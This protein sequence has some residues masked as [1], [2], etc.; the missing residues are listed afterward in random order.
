MAGTRSQRVISYLRLHPRSTCRQ[1]ARA[2]GM[3]SAAV[4]HHLRG[5]LAEK[6]IRAILVPGTG[7][8]RPA[9]EYVIGNDLLGNNGS[10][11]A[12]ALL[13]DAR[14]RGQVAR[15]A[16]EGA[17][18]AALVSACGPWAA[19]AGLASVQMLVARLNDQNYDARWEAGSEGPRILLANCPYREIV[20]KSPELC[21]VDR[22]LIAH[23]SKAQVEGLNTGPSRAESYQPCVFSLRY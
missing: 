21:R 19:A 23:L 17:V 1:V 22:R 20:G 15:R 2:L 5:L 16:A 13:G 8:G 9:R 10:L 12:A 3:R 11:V 14:H 4:A 6:R 18:L 7:R